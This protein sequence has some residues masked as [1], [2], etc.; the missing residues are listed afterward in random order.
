MTNPNNVCN[1]ELENGISCL[2]AA[3]TVN[4]AKLC[5]S[6]DTQVADPGFSQGRGANCPKPFIFL[7]IC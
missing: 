6:L 5:T 4:W 3:C 7:I 2:I 1:L